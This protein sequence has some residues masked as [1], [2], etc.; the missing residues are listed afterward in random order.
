[1]FINQKQP[2]ERLRHEQ[3]IRGWSQKR[4]ADLIDTSKE[5]VGLWERGERGT[6]KK[7]QERLCELFGKSAEELGFIKGARKFETPNVVVSQQPSQHYN[8]LANVSHGAVQNF[9]GKGDEFPEGKHSNPIS[10][11]EQASNDEL[12]SQIS[13]PLSIPSLFRTDID[14]FAHLS[15]VLSKPS[16]VSESEITYFDQQTR[17]YWRAREETALP[18]ATLYAYIIRHID[19]IS[20][21]LARSHLPTLRLYLCEIVCRTVLLAGI[22]LYDMGQ[23]AK[24]RQHYQVAF[25]AAMEANN[26]VLQAI[27]WGWMSFT[28]TYAKQYA[29]ALNCVQHARS[30]VTQTTDSMT[31]AWLGAIE[32]EVQAHLHNRDACLLAISTMERGMRGSPPQDISYLF[33]FNPVLLLGYKGVCLQQFYRRQEPATNGFLQEAKESLEQALASEAA[34]KRKLYYLNDLAGV[35]ARQ[36]EV[37]IACAYIAQSIPLM[38]Q[39]GSG[40]KTIRKHLLQ[41][42]TLLQPHEHT[43]SVQ[44][45]DGQILP[46]LIGIQAEEA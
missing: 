28:W 18:A 10:L 45:L 34:I 35:Y 33:E 15:T 46:L 43:S 3:E 1:M 29:E 2:N 38:M 12:Q 6:G 14:V 17:L 24:A 41:V 21:L 11:I 9:I 37:E 16:V 8:G 4:V 26:P 44:A 30:F 5:I 39:V 32:A 22:L 19:D 13:T 36:G 25:K 23:Y 31:R 7:Y 27:I 20:I 40:S 42:R